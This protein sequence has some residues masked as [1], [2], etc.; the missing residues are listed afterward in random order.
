MKIKKACKNQCLYNKIVY[1][2]IESEYELCKIF[3]VRGVDYKRD[4]T[5]S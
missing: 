2:Y 3:N 5:C 4:N 1:E